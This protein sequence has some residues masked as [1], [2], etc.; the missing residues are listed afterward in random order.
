MGTRQV[1]EEEMAAVNQEILRMGVMVEEAL[2]Q[3]V[4]SLVNKDG[5]LA[6]AVVAGDAAINQVEQEI[7]DRCIVLIAREQPVATD[8]RRLVTSLK[9]VTQLERM[10]D[11]ALHV[12]KGTLRLLPET[13]MKPL[14][15]IP[16][17]A[18]IGIGMIRDVLTA[19]LDNNAERAREVASRDH[20]VDELHNQVMREVFTYMMEN[21]KNIPQSISLLF[22]SRFLERVGDHVTNICEWVVYGA[23]GERVE[24]NQ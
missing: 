3:A 2:H 24:L 10:G 11:H 18:E 22:I 16:R 7:E 19:F 15:D 5:E 1:F 13:Y 21:T 17:M 20:L 12:A 6:R 8:L 4:E 14:I 9:I 23:T